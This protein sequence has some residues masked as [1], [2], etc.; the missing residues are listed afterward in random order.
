M[1][2]PNYVLTAQDSPEYSTSALATVMAN[3]GGIIS[4]GLYIYLRTRNMPAELDD[5]PTPKIRS[6][7]RAPSRHP[8][9][10]EKEL[11]I[12][13]SEPPHDNYRDDRSMSSRPALASIISEYY[14]MHTI[15]EIPRSPTMSTHSERETTSILRMPPSPTSQYS[16]DRRSSR[17]PSIF[18]QYTTHSFRRL[19]DEINH[20]IA[21]LRNQ[22]TTPAKNTSVTPPPPTSTRKQSTTYTIFPPN[23]DR[24]PTAASST[25]S[26]SK[27]QVPRTLLRAPTRPSR[28][29]VPP[30]NLDRRQS[31]FKQERPRAQSSSHSSAHSGSLRI[32][33]KARVGV[34][35]EVAI[36]P[37]PDNGDAESFMEI[38]IW[39]KETGAGAD[40]DNRV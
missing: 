23:P 2:V 31:S 37:R 14:D 35:F 25:A 13:V 24:P 39:K 11:S 22:T 12:V 36:P 32:P 7:E 21:G 26:V 34:P 16:K 19:G 17:A 1:M 9:A 29:A 10:L 3:I 20:M 8:T 27:L 4:C 38:L 33:P 28:A 40:P 30:I 18:S 6:L 5:E 15:S